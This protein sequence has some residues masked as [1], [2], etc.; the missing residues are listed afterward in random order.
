MEAVEGGRRGWRRETGVRYRSL[1]F[2]EHGHTYD[3]HYP[4][5]PE[6]K[7]ETGKIHILRTKATALAVFFQTSD[8]DTDY[9]AD[10]DS[11]Y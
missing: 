2:G 11:E 9:D 3:T 5:I 8:K 4:H 7:K 6:G 1:N 10:G